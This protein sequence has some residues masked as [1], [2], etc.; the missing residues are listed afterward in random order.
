[1]AEVPRNFDDIQ[2]DIIYAKNEIKRRLCQDAD[3]IKYLHNSELERVHA[4]PDDY[5]NVNI[6]PY[7]RI[8]GTQD[9]V[10][11]YIC[12]SVDDIEDSRFTDYNNNVMKTQQVQ[13]VIFCHE[14]DMSTDV[15][16]ERHDVLGYIIRDIFN[17][18]NLIGLQLKLT[19]N[20]E[21]VTDTH[22]ST[23]TLVFKSSKPNSLDNGI[24]RSRFER[25]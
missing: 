12:F 3:L 24:P 23:R 7:I 20:K 6:F 16:I 15:G 19:V 21:S 10:Q 22:F 18:S 4:D 25:K 9:K 2:D 1:M 13:F 5:Y 11:N 8:P 14:D 17:W